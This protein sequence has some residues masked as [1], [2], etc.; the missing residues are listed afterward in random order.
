MRRARASWATSPQVRSSMLGNRSRDTKPELAIRR[1]AHALGL[2]YR[3]A[4]YPLPGV[5]RTADMVFPK[6]RVAVFIDGCF[7]HGCKVH[8]VAPGTNVEFWQGKVSLNRRR[9]AE[10]DDRLRRAG[11]TVV[12][13]WEHEDAVVAAARIAR[14]VRGRP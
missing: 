5:R 8:Y 3:V 7:W 13:I 4:A 6:K 2:R 10:V 11:W 1:R 14:A 12:R 9:D